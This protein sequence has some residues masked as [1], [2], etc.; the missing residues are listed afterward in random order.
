MLESYYGF[1]IDSNKCLKFNMAPVFSGKPAGIIMTFGQKLDYD[2]GA[3]FDYEGDGI[4]MS[5][6]HRDF[7]DLT[8]GAFCTDYDS[9]KG[10]CV[11]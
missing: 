11:T 9:S 5:I 1:S 3:A 4:I 2:I 6:E 10:I 8:L 7:P